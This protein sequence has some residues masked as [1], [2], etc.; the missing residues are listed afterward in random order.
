[1]FDVSASLPPFDASRLALMNAGRDDV[2]HGV[3]DHSLDE[4]AA[5]LGQLER[6]LLPVVLQGRIIPAAVDLLPGE[7]V[8]VGEKAVGGHGV[9]D[10][11]VAEVD[12]EADAGE[13]E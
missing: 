1:M 10:G 3:D 13:L 4:S 5:V 9:G 6:Q 2:L 8:E 7:A 12:G 11:P